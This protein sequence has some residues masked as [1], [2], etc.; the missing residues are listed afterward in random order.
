MTESQVTEYTT[1][2]EGLLDPEIYQ[3]FIDDLERLGRELSLPE[4]YLGSDLDKIVIVPIGRVGNSANL[5]VRTERFW[6]YGNKYG[7]DVFVEHSEQEAVP[8]KLDSF[9]KS[10]GLH[11]ARYNILETAA[12]KRIESNRFI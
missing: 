9:L 6:I 10:A 4:G 3:H 5:V 7:F 8:V 2:E 11:L 1:L 12:P